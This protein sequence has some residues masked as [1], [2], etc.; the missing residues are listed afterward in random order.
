MPGIAVIGAQWGDE[1]KGKVVD[2]LASQADFVVR[3]SGGANAGHTVVVD[4]DIFKVHHLPVGVLH[5]GPVSILGGGMVIDPWTFREELEQ[6]KERRDPGE[7]YI[8]QEAHLV[9]PHNRKNDEGGGFVGTT[10]RGIGPTY[11][12]KARR[13]GIRFGDLK[14]EMVLRERLSRL[15]EAKPNSTAAVN[16]TSVDKAFDE[17]IEIRDYCLPLVKDT[18]ALVR[19][20]LKDNKK[21][22]FEGGQGTMLDL[23][24]GTY[25]YLT[26]S[27][28][29]VGGILVGAGVSH[30]ALN[31]THGIVKAFTSRVGHGPFMTEIHDE[32]MALRLRGTGANQWD[33]YGTTTGRPRRVGWLD[34]VQVKYACDINGFDSL[35]ITKLDVLSGLETIKV[36]TAY[37]NDQPVYTDMAGWG[38]LKGIDKRQDLPKEVLSYLELIESFTET[39]VSMFSTGPKRSET[40]GTVSWE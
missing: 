16:W 27:H 28:P 9:L 6:F 33:E 22:L 14:D 8:S 34:L 20:G 15:L 4:Q 25:P 5:D 40:F 19:Q 1:G 39:P 29:T 26:S 17:L 38:D 21:V 2:A 11:S 7:V 24:Y 3:Y 36:C 30:K 23:S 31:G 18:G 32:T 37:E 10:G 12:D 35:V 13:V